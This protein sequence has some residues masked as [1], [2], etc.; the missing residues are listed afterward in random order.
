MIK[1]TG[2]IDLQVLGIGGDGHWAF[3]EPGSSFDSRTRVEYL[4]QKTVDDNYEAFYKKQEYQ[5]KT[6]HV[7]PLLWESRLY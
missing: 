2:G 4:T 1:D 7:K 6:C 5:K 3:N